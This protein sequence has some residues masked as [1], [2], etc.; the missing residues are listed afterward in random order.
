MMNKVEQK[1]NIFLSQTILQTAVEAA[2]NG[3]KKENLTFNFS[4]PEAYSADRL[5]AFRENYKTIGKCWSW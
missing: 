4:Y 5:R 3:I 2:A 1:F